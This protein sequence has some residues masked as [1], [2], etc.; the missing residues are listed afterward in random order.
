MTLL[1]LPKVASRQKI[2]LASHCGLLRLKASEIVIRAVDRKVE[3]K[4][5]T[6]DF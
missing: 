2:G 3:H 4:Q 1:D 6:A 5:D